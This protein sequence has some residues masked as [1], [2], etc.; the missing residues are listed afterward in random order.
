MGERDPKLIPIESWDELAVGM[1]VWIR[2]GCCDKLYG[3][4]IIVAFK[5]QNRCVDE[6]LRAFVSDAYKFEPKHVCKV[7]YY[8][9]PK[10][11]KGRYPVGATLITPNEVEERRVF[12]EV[13]ENPKE[14]KVVEKIPIDLKS[15][16]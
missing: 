5:P 4:C 10:E 14:T 12:V 3:R 13:V 11:W 16:L 9:V 15:R 8:P 2:L 1:P 6:H 7:M